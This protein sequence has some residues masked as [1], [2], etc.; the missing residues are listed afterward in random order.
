MLFDN[1]IQENP[2]VEKLRNISIETTRRP[3]NKRLYFSEYHHGYNVH[4]LEKSSHCILAILHVKY[5]DT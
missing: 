1:T 5:T 3:M 2:L 4:F